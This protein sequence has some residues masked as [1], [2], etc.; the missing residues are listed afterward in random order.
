LKMFKRLLEEIDS[1]F[2]RDPAAKSRIEVV[3]CYPGFHA[4]LI[5]RVSHRLWQWRWKLVARVLS[6]F[7]RFITGVE[8]HPGAKIG[9]RFFIDHGMGVVIGETA[10]IGNDVTIYHGVTLG[11]V[12]PG[13]EK[14][15]ALRHPQIGNNVIVG[16]GAQ[17]LGPIKVGDGA[18]IGSNA[19]VVRDVAKNATMVGIPAREVVKKSKKSEDKEFAAYG[20]AAESGVDSR[21]LAIDNLIKQVETLTKKMKTLESNEDDIE[22]TANKW[23]KRS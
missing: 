22:H 19:V 10:K 9:R 23:E 1:F 12:A 18:R 2:D 4:V 14:K 11:G 15:G 17:L 8:I 13:N 20:T 6:Q 7:A 3:L 21:Q 16:S 5:Y